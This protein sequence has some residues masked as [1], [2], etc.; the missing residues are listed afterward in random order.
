M[1]KYIF[2]VLLLLLIATIACSAVGTVTP[3]PTEV[4]I[5]NTPRNTLIPTRTLTA[6]STQPI[7]VPTS[8]EVTVTAFPTPTQIVADPT[9]TYFITFYTPDQT[10]ANDDFIEVN[11][12]VVNV[13]NQPYPTVDCTVVEQLSQGEIRKVYLIYE[14]VTLGEVW[15]RINPETEEIPKWISVAPERCRNLNGEKVSCAIFKP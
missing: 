7:I 10:S 6:T 4:L 14:N 9:A 11:S 8:G 2:Y 1:K 15:A 13:R 12:N 5:T 3:E